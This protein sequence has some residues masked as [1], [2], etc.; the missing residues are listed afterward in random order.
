MTVIAIPEPLR[1]KLGAEAA[2]ALVELL[3]QASQ[4]TRD[5]VVSIAAERFQRRLAEEIGKLRTDLLAEIA[6]VRAELG[7]QIG[8][9]RAELGSQI[10]SVRA[11][12]AGA[13]ADLIR[14]VFVFWAGQAVLVVGLFGTLLALLKR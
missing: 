9:V 6:S 14:W 12:L 1:D 4:R 2:Q 11:E 13:K 5:D 3:N 8:S 7:S 10:G